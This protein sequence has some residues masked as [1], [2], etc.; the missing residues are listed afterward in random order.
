MS[1]H[2]WK[3]KYCKQDV[4]WPGI[5]V[6]Q[7]C[8]LSDWAENLIGPI[9][10]AIVASVTIKAMLSLISD[11]DKKIHAKEIKEQIMAEL[12]DQYNLI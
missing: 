5:E 12:L 2:N 6:C 9:L 4:G 8:A 3:C 7:D 10:F 11:Y 1:E